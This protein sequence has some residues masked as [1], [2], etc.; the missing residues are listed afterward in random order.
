MLK[1]GRHVCKS[2]GHDTPFKGAVAGVESGFPFIA[3]SDTDQVV[4]VTEVDFC[5]ETCLLWAVVR[6]WSPMDLWQVHPALSSPTTPFRPKVCSYFCYISNTPPF[7]PVPL[8]SPFVPMFPVSLISVSM[9]LWSSH[10]L[11][12]V[13]SPHSCLSLFHASTFHS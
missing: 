13:F 11:H 5:I 8:V 1:S 4:C 3:L 6:Y 2:E 7:I 9:S 10:L 12:I